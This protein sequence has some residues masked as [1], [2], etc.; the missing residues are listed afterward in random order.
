MPID[1]MP[2]FFSFGIPRVVRSRA[3]GGAS[4]RTRFVYLR[5]AVAGFVSLPDERLTPAPDPVYL[6]VIAFVQDVADSLFQIFFRHRDV[7]LVLYEAEFSER[8]SD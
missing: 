8:E 6:D 7:V 1:H 4:G 2:R 3:A 5:G